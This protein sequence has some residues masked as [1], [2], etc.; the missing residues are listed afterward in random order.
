MKNNL[1]KI[2]ISSI[3]FLLVI[4]NIFNNETINIIL[5]IISYLIV[6][7][8]VIINAI[9]NIFKKDLFDENF[10]MSIATIG[11]ICINEIEEAIMVMILYQIGELFQDYAVDK[12]KKSITS[13]MDL[14]V[15]SVNLL[16][17]KKIINVKPEEVKVNDVIIVSPGEKIPLD[18]III[19]GESFIDNS[20]LT[21]E[22]KLKSIKVNDYVLSGSINKENIIK[23]K[24]KKLYK[25][26]TINKILELLEN[27]PS[28]KS[29]YENFITI[30]SK[31][32]TKIV[33]LIALFIS[34]IIPIITKENFYNSL[35][36]GLSFLV[37]SCPCALVISVPLTYFSSIG[38]SSK[39]GILIKGSNYIEK[40][41]NI[42]TIV[43]DKTGTLTKGEFKV[44]K[45]VPNNISKEELLEI[46]VMSEY[47]IKHPIALKIKEEYKKEIDINR[48]K[49]VKEIS[50]MGVHS[51]IDN[52]DVLVGSDKLLDKYNI[53]YKNS[54]DI[55]TIIYIAINNEYKGYILISDKIK[56][57][58]KE[59]IKKLKKLNIE[60][61]MLTGDLNIVGNY[62]GKDLDIDKIYSELL[63]NEK[64]KIVNELMNNSKDNIIFV[65]DGVNDA[66]VLKCADVG[67]SMGSIGSDSAI[68][69]SDIVIMNDNLDKIYE[70]IKI[71]KKTM[72]IVYENIIFSILIKVVVLLLSLFGINSLWQAVFADV[73]VTIIVSLNALRMLFINV[74]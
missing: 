61:I 15:K 10:L 36:K 65:G 54:N 66:P 55:G 68:S 74:K 8:E 27:T 39:K 72:K 42:K 24:V 50:G 71:S 60:T 11:A 17:N 37:V 16:K 20:E 21:G 41:N 57:N 58:A 53:K 32:Y 34:F 51:Q 28:R 25:D 62:V 63:P 22:T 59:T 1:I 18:G 14:K 4:L 12:S 48:I 23:I 13:L 45:I 73:G 70:L 6:G 49:K 46:T 40:M 7:Y 3:L 5:Y 43:F 64:V 26:G 29:K 69:V 47:Y 31:Y 56:D 67:I 2:I 33:I 44:Q 19:E 9:K 52:L 30:F 35:Y 38:A